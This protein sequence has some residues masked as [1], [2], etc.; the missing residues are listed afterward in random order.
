MSEE[1]TRGGSL[2]SG[3]GLVRC[4]DTQETPVQDT[5]R[6]FVKIS[7]AKPLRIQPV[8]SYRRA[9]SRYL[10][11]QILATCRDRH[12]LAYYKKV[13]RLLPERV[14]FEVLSQVKEAQATGRI[15]ESSGAMF[16]D[17]IQ[18]KA[19]ELGIEFR[20]ENRESEHHLETDQNSNQELEPTETRITA[21]R[22]RR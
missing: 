17:L 18:R 7:P 4:A 19:K 3:Q 20:N 6:T 15:R 16:T 9:K 12:S 1:Q 5:D 2:Q 13:V 11:D 10:T 21:L 8:E 22:M 14:I